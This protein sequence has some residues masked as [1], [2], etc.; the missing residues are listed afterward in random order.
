MHLPYIQSYSLYLSCMSLTFKIR[1]KLNVEDVCIISGISW[2]MLG[3]NLPSSKSEDLF[4]N[5]S[6]DLALYLANSCVDIVMLFLTPFQR[7]IVT[8]KVKCFI[9]I[10]S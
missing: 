10:L 4:T 8:N 5:I 1:P 2:Q 9:F 7:M 3:A 6:T